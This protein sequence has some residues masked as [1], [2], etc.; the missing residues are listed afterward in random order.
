MEEVDTEMEEESVGEVPPLIREASKTM[1]SISSSHR[2]T[3]RHLR[4][5]LEFV[6]YTNKGL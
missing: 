5:S 4:I 2:A 3:K 6:H 1:T